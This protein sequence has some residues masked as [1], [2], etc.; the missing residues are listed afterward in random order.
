MRYLALAIILGACGAAPGRATAPSPPMTPARDLATA[1][2][3]APR[4]EGHDARLSV[5]DPRV[6]DLDIIRITARAKAPGGELEL[7]SV[8]SADLYKQA[9]EAARAPRARRDPDDVEVD[10]ARIA[11]Q[12]AVIV[13]ATLGGR[14]GPRGREIAR[15]R[16]CG[17]H[18]RATG[19]AAA[20]GHSDRER[21]VAHAQL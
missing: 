15:R 4:G 13:S 9:N 12:L 7:T 20:G 14:R 17:W 21:E 2:S 18:G 8:A 10:H 6:V 19:R 11:R 1:R 16:H 3:A 5:R